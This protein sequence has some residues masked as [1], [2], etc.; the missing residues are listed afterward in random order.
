MVEVEGDLGEGGV[1]DIELLVDF[2]DGY[3]VVGRGAEAPDGGEVSGVV[4][5]YSCC[6]FSKYFSGIDCTSLCEPLS[7][8]PLNYIIKQ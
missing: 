1:G 8:V 6:I 2:P 7:K 4:G 3:V 5:D